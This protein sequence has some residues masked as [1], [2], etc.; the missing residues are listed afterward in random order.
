MTMAYTI[1]KPPA[2]PEDTA[3]AEIIEKQQVSPTPKLDLAGEIIRAIKEAM[4]D[5]RPNV[6]DQTSPVNKE[7]KSTES[8]FEDADECSTEE[9]EL[10]KSEED[11]DSNEEINKPNGMHEVRK[12]NTVMTSVTTAV[13]T[14]KHPT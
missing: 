13:T 2:T 6:E 12:I 3:E 8:D 10:I 9:W 4:S 14:G 5:P 1:A 11:I 7:P